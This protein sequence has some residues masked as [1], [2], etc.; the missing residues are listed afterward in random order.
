MGRNSIRTADEGDSRTRG[1]LRLHCGVGPLL[2]MSLEAG[3][4]GGLDLSSKAVEAARA[5][6]AADPGSW[7][8]WE[9][10]TRMRPG[11][12][13]DAIRVVEVERHRLRSAH[14][15]RSRLVVATRLAEARAS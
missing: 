2:E 4:A 13:F 11:R 9:P 15:R 10:E 1:E 8:A 7:G 6:F 3:R 12:R 14:Q 5:R